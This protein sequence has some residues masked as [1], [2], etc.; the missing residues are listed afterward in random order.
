MIRFACIL[1]N[2]VKNIISVETEDELSPILAQYQAI[3]Q[4]DIAERGWKFDGTRVFPSV[5]KESVDWALSVVYDPLTIEFAKIKRQFIGENIFWKIT[6][7]GKTRLVGDFM[8][9][10]EKWFNRIAPI[11]AITEV[12]IAKAKL[13]ADPAL[14][15]S[16]SPFVTIDR[17]NWYKSSILAAVAK[18]KGA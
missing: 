6:E 3:V 8:E 17:L 11:E 2:E 1:D 18:T 5:S 7:Q 15:T 16:L 14:A 9:P 10:I 13:A 12:E 4:S